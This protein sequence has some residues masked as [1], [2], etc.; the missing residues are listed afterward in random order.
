VGRVLYVAGGIDR[1]EAVECLRTF[2]ALDLGA[3]ETGWKELPSWPGP[4]R[5]LA[6]SGE[7]GGAFYVFGGVELHA[8]S[9]GKPV[10]RYLADGYRFEGGKGWRRVADM[11]R[12]VAG[13]AS[14]L[15][16]LQGRLVVVSGDDGSKVGFEPKS[17]HPGFPRDVL[18]YDVR[19][20]VWVGWGMSPLSR[21]TVPAVVWRG[22]V[23]IPGGETRPGV[24]T[25]EVWGLRVRSG[26]E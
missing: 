20:D 2:W 11:P 1:P 6:M 26:G 15:P 18:A 14:P 3:I 4:A 8:D 25:P 21:A 9:Q 16:G 12:A 24:R 10:R 13:A 5:M 23:V 19:R 22:Q 17:E 7:A